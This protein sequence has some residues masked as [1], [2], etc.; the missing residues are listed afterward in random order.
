MV[1][2]AWVGGSLEVPH[3]ITKVRRRA[4]LVP[5][6]WSKRALGVMAATSGDAWRATYSD[7]AVSYTHLT[8]PTKRIV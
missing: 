1:Y 7:M 5:N 6:K 8:L 3:H 2:Y 4:H